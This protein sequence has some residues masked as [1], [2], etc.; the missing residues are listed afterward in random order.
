MRF[1]RPVLRQLLA[2]TFSRERF[3]PRQ[4]LFGLALLGGVALLSL[5]NR[6]L[7]SLDRLFYPDF[8]DEPV[9]SPIFIVANPRSGTTFLHRLLALDPQFSSLRLW[10]TMAPNVCTNRL[11]DRF[12]AADRQ[13]GR[14]VARMAE[15]IDRFFFGGWQGIHDM[16]LGR[17][18][19]DEMFWVYALLTPSILLAFPFPDALHDLLRADA[20]P[21][22]ERAKVAEVYRS[23]L[24]RVLYAERL[25][26]RSRRVLLGKSALAAGRIHTMREALPGL[27]VV[28]LVRHPYETVSSTISMLSKVWRFHSPELAEDGDEASGWTQIVHHAYRTLHEAGTQFEENRYLELRYDDLVRDPQAAIER[29]YATFGLE[30]SDAYR[31]ILARECERARDWESGHEHDLSSYGLSKAAVYSELKDVFETYDFAP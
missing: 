20:L 11:V 18:E 5:L 29:I 4:A 25:A 1:Y 7:R 16:G 8:A 30:M 12:E 31:D 13:L 9:E 24:K 10:Q 23:H 2:L 3:R 15:T 27:R 6:G 17:T 26:G 21:P 14:P 28:H 19:E 22:E